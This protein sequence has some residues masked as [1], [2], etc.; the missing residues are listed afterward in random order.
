MTFRR[1]IALVSAAAVAIAIAAASVVVY[2][3]VR[4]QLRDQVDDDLRELASGA[5]VRTL[6]APPPGKGS[7]RR[8]GIAL[9]EIDLDRPLARI[10]RGRRPSRVALALPE[11]P[12][13]VPGGFGQLIDSQGRVFGAPA[14][15]GTL[16][17][18]DAAREVATRRR[19][20]FFADVEHDGTHLRVLTEPAGPRQAIQVARSLDELDATLSRL[21]LILTAIALA[22]VGLA[23]LL[24]RAIARAAISPV[25][26]LTEA[27][28]HV[29]R[30]RDL[31]RRIESG[32]D[33]ELGRLAAS[34]NSMLA[35]LE[36]AIGARRQLVAD[37]SHELRTPLTSLRTNIE[38]L[39]R[40]NGLSREDR[41]RVLRDLVEQ[42]DELGLL[43]GN[44]IDLAREEERPVAEAAIRLDEV[45]AA[46]VERA[47][48]RSHDVEIS[49]HVD[50]CVVYG[51]EDRIDR[52]VA[53]LLDNAVKWGA[54]PAPRSR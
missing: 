32:A 36:H 7:G 15:S 22:G 12:L 24:G 29:R 2:V 10:D 18:S 9:P 33:D 30:T 46:A 52:A 14:A 27:A 54:L 42:L 35:E 11:Q 40:T 19:P 3:V 6:P 28:E 50:P 51:I 43:V 17:V 44:L 53:N 21:R 45:A 31:G 41:D 13:G 49:I 16:P 37:A 38:V 20:S 23:A 48:R 26:K 1:R 34:L 8:A 25:V 5:T 39:G 47:R 4:D